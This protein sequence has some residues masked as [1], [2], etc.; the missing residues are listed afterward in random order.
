[1]WRLSERV[2]SVKGRGET[3]QRLRRLRHNETRCGGTDR[4]PATRTEVPSKETLGNSAD[5]N[6]LICSP[7][8]A[9]G[10]VRNLLANLEKRREHV[11]VGRPAA[12]VERHKHPSS[13]RQV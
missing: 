4:N 7:V 1:M 13:Q 8:A 6:G 10:E 9:A 11:A 12:S 2:E 3:G 5:R